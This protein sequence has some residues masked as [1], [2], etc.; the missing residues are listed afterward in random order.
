MLEQPKLHLEAPFLLKVF[1]ASPICSFSPHKIISA[2]ALGIPFY[3]LSYSVILEIF[4]NK[5]LI[6]SFQSSPS[7]Q[8]QWCQGLGGQEAMLT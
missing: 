5:N 8:L 1:Y 4:L 2:S 6:I 3:G 7:Y